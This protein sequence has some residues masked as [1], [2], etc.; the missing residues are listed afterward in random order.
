[1]YG[2]AHPDDL[3]AAGGIALA[4]G[5]NRVRRSRHGGRTYRANATDEE[6]TGCCRRRPHLDRRR[7]R[8]R[9][10]TLPGWQQPGGGPG[11]SPGARQRSPG[12]DGRKLAVDPVV[13]RLLRPQ[14]LQR[15]D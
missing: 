13:S 4:P 15:I 10:V 2:T 9:V 5:S 14:R 6:G 1:T 11:R 12:T 8:D 7:R 3:I